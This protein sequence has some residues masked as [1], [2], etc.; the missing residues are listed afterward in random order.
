MSRG[1]YVALSGAVAQGTALDTTATNLANAASN[2]FQRLRPV[3][4]EVLKGA[5]SKPGS[6]LHYSTVDSTALDASRGAIRT[7]GRAL[8][9]ALPEGVYLGVNTARGERYTRS[10]A[11]KVD[12]SG[13]LTTASGAKVARE[14]GQPISVD[15]LR[16][17]GVS[18]EGNVLQDGAV[19]ARL[20]L[21]KFDPTSGPEHEGEGL[22]VGRGEALPAD[23]RLDVG[24]LEDSNAPVVSSM[25][26]LVTASR[27]FE[28]FQRMLDTFGE[29]DRKVLSTVPGPTE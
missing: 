21:V 19:V 23:S 7:T 26:D 2:G 16:D 25:I 28:A 5:T 8:D 11:L 10:G 27:T 4:R 29:I 17:I 22:L 24:S 18:P 20:R 15:P 14:D 3:F 12:A 9:V 1:I 6:G 13:S